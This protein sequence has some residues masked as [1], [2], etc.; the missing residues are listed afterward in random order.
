MVVSLFHE[1]VTKN[2][3]QEPGT[4][5]EIETFAAG[6]QANFTLFE[7]GD[8]KGENIIP[9]YAF[10]KMMTGEVGPRLLVLFFFCIGLIHLSVFHM[11]MCVINL[12]QNVHEKYNNVAVRFVVQF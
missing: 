4:P 9:V 3:P 6:K 8:V 11:Y 5:Q 7:K 2:Y 1:R 12:S 10:L